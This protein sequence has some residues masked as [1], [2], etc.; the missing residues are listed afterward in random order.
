MIL[1]RRHHSCLPSPSR[2]SSIIATKQP[3]TFKQVSKTVKANKAICVPHFCFILCFQLEFGISAACA[4]A[5]PSLLL[6]LLQ[7]FL[8]RMVVPSGPPKL[9][10]PS[11]WSSHLPCYSSTVQPLGRASCKQQL[12][13]SENGWHCNC[14]QVGSDELKRS[15]IKTAML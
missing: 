14:T 4:A 12:R 13:H 8:I 5:S 6:C 9:P 10:L 15:V 1:G 3:L 7:D 11:V 2:S